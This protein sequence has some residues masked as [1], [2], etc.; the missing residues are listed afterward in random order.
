MRE[1]ARPES[2]RSAGMHLSLGRVPA[3]QPAIVVLELI[4]SLPAGKFE[5]FG[6]INTTSGHEVAKATRDHSEFALAFRQVVQTHFG[7]NVTEIAL[8]RV[9]HGIASYP[10]VRNFHRCCIVWWQMVDPENTVHVI[11]AN[12][13]KVSMKAIETDREHCGSVQICRV[14]DCPLNF[15]EA[16]SQA[17]NF[18]S[19]TTTETQCDSMAHYTY[20]RADASEYS[21]MECTDEFGNACVEVYICQPLAK[22]FLD[23]RKMFQK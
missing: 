5:T 10:L 15:G 2:L 3:G 23:D 17:A 16:T 20:S 8:I 22:C 6:M 19:A 11:D 14:E 13:T 7:M 9:G 1:P 21:K 4:C 18:T 12:S